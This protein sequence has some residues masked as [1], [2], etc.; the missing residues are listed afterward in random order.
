MT[1][2]NDI[3]GS[4]FQQLNIRS[5]AADGPPLRVR[6]ADELDR[7]AG[8]IEGEATG[9]PL[10][11]ARLQQ[12]LADTQFDLAY[13]DRAL[14][15]LTKAA[16]TREAV[17][18]PDHPDTLWSKR[19]LAATLR[20]L[21][22]RDQAFA[23][24][25]EIVE[26]RKAAQGPDDSDTLTSMVD[27]A[28]AHRGTGREAEGIRLAEYVY[29]VRKAKGG[30]DSE[31]ASDTLFTM[32]L[33]Y[34]DVGQAAKALPMFEQV[35]ENRRARFGVDSAQAANLLHSVGYACAL[36]GQHRRAALLFEESL[37][38]LRTVYGVHHVDTFL[39]AMRLGRTA[40]ALR[41][42]GQLEGA[43][44]A[45]RAAL[46][47]YEVFV[48]FPT[49]HL[50]PRYAQA[51]RELPGLRTNLVQLLR[52]AG[53][54]AEADALAR[55]ALSYS[56]ALAATK[57]DLPEGRLL[58]AQ[59]HELLGEHATAAE[60]YSAA[61]KRWPS[62]AHLNKLAW[63]LATCPDEKVRNP[64]RVVELARKAVDQQSKEG[65]FRNTL[66]VA[67]YRAG[68]SAGAVD[69]LT[70]SGELRKGG[71]TF[72][73]FFLAMA[74]HQLGRNDEARKWYGRAAAWVQTNAPGD[75]ELARFRTE[76]SAVLGIEAG[77]APREVIR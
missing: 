57:P 66:G 11:V 63:L 22:N 15:L 2:A 52:A 67:L 34:V 29:E 33:L 24:F 36:T 18:G 16:R 44:T 39:T 3:L 54:G 45:F 76:A 20:A 77:P 59:A 47:E 75:D 32:A 72:A 12:I 49:Q 64:K 23:M 13:P 62:P 38:R 27:F 50:S 31:L 4:V 68:D 30:A 55:R 21:G 73:W 26:R 56:E 41:K 53:R 71:D 43:E 61:L 19:R 9:D 14:P 1:R 60:V 6:L 74:H 51:V 37:V 58:T 10:A 35:L 69:E 65:A 48:A 42:G 5:E 70:R 46:E 8:Q 40:A 28:L 25:R 17:L 7:A